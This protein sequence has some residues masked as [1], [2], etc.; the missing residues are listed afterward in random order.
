MS[1][2][3]IHTLETVLGLVGA[4]MIIKLIE[5]CSDKYCSNTV[6]TTVI[7]E[8]EQELN[9]EIHEV[10]DDS[11]SDITIYNLPVKTKLA[12]DEIQTPK[13]YINTKY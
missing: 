2:N 4:T 6:V 12:D 11:K 1:F 10:A 9:R 13:C 7:H 5:K 3:G 8:T